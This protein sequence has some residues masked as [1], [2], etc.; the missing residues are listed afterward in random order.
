[1]LTHVRRIVGAS[2]LV[3]TAVATASTASAATLTLNGALTPANTVTVGTTLSGTVQELACNVNAAVTKGQVCVTIDPRPYERVLAIARANLAAAEAQLG[4]DAASVAS[5]KL[6]FQR[7]STLAAQGVV[8]RVAVNDFETT[9][10][11][12]ESQLALDRAAIEQRQAQIAAA[13]LNL[14]Y[15]KIASPISGTILE[16]RIAAGETVTAGLEVPALF[17]VASDLKRLRIVLEVGEADVGRVKTGDIASISAKAFPDRRFNGTIGEIGN[18][19]KVAG[20]ATSYPVVVEVDNAD[21][22]LRPGMSAVVEIA[23]AGG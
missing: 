17:V 12:A 23:G 3:A 8:S 20:G 15:T 2:V 14:D 13:E 4:K 16:T 10:Q 7:K 22:A 18:V 5:A 9:Y 6:T 1:M 19:P 11:Q 21:L